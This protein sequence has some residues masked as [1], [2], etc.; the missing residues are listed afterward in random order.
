MNGSNLQ[1][2]RKLAGYGTGAAYAAHLGVGYEAYRQW[3]SDPMGGRLRLRRAWE[4]ADDLGCTIDEVVGRTAIRRIG[5]AEVRALECLADA[6]LE[7]VM[8][9]ADHLAASHGAADMRAA[10]AARQAKLLA[11]AARLAEGVQ[12]LLGEALAA[13]P[14]GGPCDGHIEDAA[15]G[16]EGAMRSI[17]EVK[18]R[19]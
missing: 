3:E 12:D 9:F 8:A 1:R 11:E 5:A 18:C 7:A 16:I 2:L 17:A 6:D 10:A 13:A 19:L 4:L 15:F 14:A